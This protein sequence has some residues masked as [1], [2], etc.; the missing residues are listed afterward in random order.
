[1]RT[2]LASTNARL[3]ASIIAALGLSPL[4]GCDSNIEK[5]DGSGGGG[6]GGD[7]TTSTTAPSTSSSTSST[8]TTS[9]LPDHPPTCEELSTSAQ[10]GS[11]AAAGVG[12]G[13]DDGLYARECEDAEPV[14]L[15]CLDTGLDRCS[16]GFF[17]RREAV[18]CPRWHRPASEFTCSASDSLVGC[19]TDSACGP[20][21]VCNQFFFGPPAGDA[22]ECAT[23]CETDA[24][25]T[26]EQLCLCGD[27]G[28]RCVTASCQTDA[29]CGP[30]LHCASMNTGGCNP[31]LAFH[32]QSDDDACIS[33]ADC[34]SDGMGDVGCVVGAAGARACETGFGC[35]A[36]GRPLVVMGEVR[37]ARSACRD[38][39]SRSSAVVTPDES[40]RAEVAAR[41]THIA[42][43]E[44]ASVAS[45]AR[46]AM[47]L[48]AVGA[49]PHLVAGASAAMLDEIE[50]ARLAYGLA[51]A[52]GGVQVG[53]GP[54]DMSDAHPASD[55]VE[56]AVATLLEG[57]IA[58]GAAAA[59]AAVAATTAR[60][61]AVVAVL[62]RIAREEAAHAELGWKTIA[63]A[64]QRDRE[65]VA[66]A[67][68]DAMEHACRR[69]TTPKA[70]PGL[71]AFGLLGPAEREA[72]RKDTL[73][74]VVRP[75][76]EQLL[77]RA[78]RNTAG[79]MATV[80]GCT[81]GA[82]ALGG[83]FA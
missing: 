70:E 38:D 59:E 25:C 69:D 33:A 67:L 6:S 2:L 47:D 27:G 48:L 83:D 73:S 51:A 13:G 22:C 23:T 66:P 40:V 15:G 21:A 3:A 44:H 58:E 31:E 39:W 60:D 64:L 78:D 49:P 80:N 46:F 32:C 68:V 41:W 52:F 10:A 12:G 62:E 26:G 35:E 43:M 19:E 42:A 30:G 9:P 81:L 79:A 50:H 56:L 36:A 16:N 82:F 54:L 4:V 75:V 72:I 37:F 18:S 1:M 8:S 20:T 24:D 61:P 53:P 65:R 7:N 71:E 34:P 11:T 76:L 5:E 14:L 29:D 17:K 55:I 57:C 77:R 45:F 74:R 28:G 63:W